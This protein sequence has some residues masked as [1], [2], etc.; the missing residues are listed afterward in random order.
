MWTNDSLFLRDYLRIPVP[1]GGLQQQS[2]HGPIIGREQFPCLPSDFSKVPFSP[3][4][5]KVQRSQMTNASTAV[6]CAEDDL[7]Q[8]DIGK[9]FSKYDS[10]I[11][12]LKNCA[13]ERE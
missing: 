8:V 13:S 10:L 9:Y 4:R 12:K 6:A 11:V 3:Q 5:E 7:N 1:C 2:V